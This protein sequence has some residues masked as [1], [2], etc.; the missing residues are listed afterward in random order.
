M[1]TEQKKTITEL[2][3]NSLY[4]P[5]DIAEN[6]VAEHF[7]IDHA[8]F[9]ITSSVIMMTVVE[10]FFTARKTASTSNIFENYVQEKIIHADSPC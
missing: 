6:I 8:F 1:N 5:S 9:N 7:S 10:D 3:S 4:S 2:P